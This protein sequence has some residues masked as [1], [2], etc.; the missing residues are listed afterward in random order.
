MAPDGQKPARWLC[1]TKLPREMCSQPMVRKALSWG[2]ICKSACILAEITVR[3]SQEVD[4]SEQSLNSMKEEA[5]KFIQYA[6]IPESEKVEVLKGFNSSI[7]DQEQIIL[8]RQIYA[9]L[10]TYYQN[11]LKL[12]LLLKQNFLDYQIGFD[13]NTGEKF[14]FRMMKVLINILILLQR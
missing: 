9:A 10:K 7:N 4:N 14:F 12:Y 6:N 13:E 1:L 8:Q 5:K 3:K 11:T 2:T